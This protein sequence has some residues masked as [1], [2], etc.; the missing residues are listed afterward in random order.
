VQLNLLCS[1]TW[2]R[3]THLGELRNCPHT[4]E[5]YVECYYYL[6]EP[7]KFVVPLE[8]CSQPVEVAFAVL[9]TG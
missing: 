8:L 4:A 3:T 5:A 1:S 9:G 7:D 2:L 6:V